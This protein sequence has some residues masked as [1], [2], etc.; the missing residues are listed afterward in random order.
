[1]V[2]SE[3]IQVVSLRNQDLPAEDVGVIKKGTLDQQPS[4][5]ARFAAGIRTVTRTKVLKKA[6]HR[7]PLQPVS[8]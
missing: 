3:T 1:M 2:L 8:Q 6:Q 4:L 7:G 5:S